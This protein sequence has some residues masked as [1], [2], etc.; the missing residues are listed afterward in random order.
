MPNRALRSHA[1]ELEGDTNMSGVYEEDLASGQKECVEERSIIMNLDQDEIQIGQSEKETVSKELEKSACEVNVTE[2]ANAEVSSINPVTMP[3][4][5]QNMFGSMLA[6][7]KSD[8]LQRTATSQVSIS[9]LQN[10]V[11]EDVRL[12]NEK[13]IKRFERENQKLSQELTKKLYSET[14]KFSH[15]LRW[16]QDDME[17]ELVAVKGNLRVMSTEFDAKLGQQAKDTSHTADELAS[18]TVHNRQ[19][20]TKHIAKLSEELNTVKS[21]F[22]KDEEVFLKRQGEC[23]EHLHA[24]EKEKSVK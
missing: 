7:F 14:G 1:V 23:L 10:K 12:G 22:A 18:I 20:V 24:I 8:L 11:K 9:T 4:S 15:L 3:S 2:Q 6:S 17:S 19:Q 13:L 21:N 16:V 5:L